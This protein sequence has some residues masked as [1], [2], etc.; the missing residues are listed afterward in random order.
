MKTASRMNRPHTLLS[1]AAAAKRRSLTA[2]GL[3]GLGHPLYVNG[4]L[5]P[6]PVT[7]SHVPGAQGSYY[8]VPAGMGDPDP[9]MGALGAY[10][11]YAPHLGADELPGAASASLPPRESPSTTQ[12]I[13]GAIGTLAGA[14]GIYHGYK[15][16]DSIGW[17]LW[18]GLMGAAFPII[19]IPIALAQGFGER[20]GM[21]AN[22]S[23]RQRGA[24]KGVKTRAAGGTKAWDVLQTVTNQRVATMVEPSWKSM[25]Q[26]KEEAQA[27]FGDD[28]Y[29][30]S[31]RKQN[32]KRR[33]R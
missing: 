33:R 32:R 10:V 19:T 2:A 31:K 11:A 25:D 4:K 12:L 22:I 13:L 30:A 7:I 26:V 14:A 29:V 8:D 5:F 23:R 21:T 20:K 17:A 6:E 28:V 1:A 27:K 3:L 9:S 15:R 18:W 24:R 16:N